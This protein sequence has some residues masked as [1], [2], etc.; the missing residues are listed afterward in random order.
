MPRDEDE[1]DTLSLCVGGLLLKSR[2]V[3]FSPL[4]GNEHSAAACAPEARQASQGA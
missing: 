1:D 4:L 2:S 3:S